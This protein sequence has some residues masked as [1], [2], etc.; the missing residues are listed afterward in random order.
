[1]R[2]VRDARGQIVLTLDGSLPPR[3]GGPPLHVHLHEHEE[4][5]VRAGTLGAQVGTEKLIVPPGGTAVL[6]AG[7]PHCWWNAGDDLLEFSGQVVPAVDLDRYLQAV[8]A[9]LNASSNGRPSI[10]RMC[11]GAI[12]S[13]SCFRFHP[14]L[15]SGSFYLSFC[16]SD[17]SWANT[18]DRAGRVR[19]SRAPVRR[20]WTLTPRSCT[21]CSRATFR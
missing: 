14:Q 7:A 11:S 16:F 3:A 8:F 1:M 21:A 5:T 12:A 2:R 15:F 4:G 6:P 10:W 19:L 18:A 9:V 20:L 17:A 13:H